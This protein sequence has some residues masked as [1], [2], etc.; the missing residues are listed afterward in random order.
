M[1]LQP[2]VRCSGIVCVCVWVCARE[3]LYKEENKIK[4]NTCL[5]SKLRCWV[6]RNIFPGYNKSTSC[7]KV[8]DTFTNFCQFL[9]V[10]WVADFIII[11]KNFPLGRKVKGCPKGSK[12][13]NFLWKRIISQGLGLDLW[14][15]SQWNVTILANL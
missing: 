15:T 8:S 13:Y 12:N 2:Q 3:R 10:F 4:Q 7:H 5:I 9:L 11:N 1:Q 14:V 6:R